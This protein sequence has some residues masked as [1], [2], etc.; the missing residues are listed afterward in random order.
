M[1]KRIRAAKLSSV[2]LEELRS[3]MSDKF[4]YSFGHKLSD[5]ER[6]AN[7]QE[8]LKLRDEYLAEA[9]KLGLEVEE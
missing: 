8:Y 1:K 5:A 9:Q 7:Y 2:K 6:E 3:Q 4:H